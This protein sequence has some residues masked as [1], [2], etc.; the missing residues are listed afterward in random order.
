M[1]KKLS[2][3][4]VQHSEKDYR[5]IFKNEKITLRKTFDSADDVL[6]SVFF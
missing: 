5:L 4:V 3:E 1:S 6:R 2:I